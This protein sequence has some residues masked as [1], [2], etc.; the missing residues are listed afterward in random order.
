MKNQTKLRRLTRGAM[1]GAIYV[2]LTFISNTFGLASGA[3]QV[4]LSEALCVLPVVF[5]ESVAGLT[6][7]C[8]LANLLTGCVPMDILFGSLATLLGAL[9]TY[10]LRRHSN[11][12]YIPP[13]LSNVLIV[14]IVLKYAYGLGDAWW[15]LVLTVG[16]GEIISCVILGRICLGVI[17]KTKLH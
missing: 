1:I 7:G 9:G 6:V 16:A 4:R 11:L 5:P 17:K 14:P 15:Y 2:V 3:V 13:V 8:F 10:A 12:L